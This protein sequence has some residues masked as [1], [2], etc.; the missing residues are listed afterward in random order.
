VNLAVVETRVKAKSAF[1]S[2]LLSKKIIFHGHLLPLSATLISHIRTTRQNR[3]SIPT[4]KSRWPISETPPILVYLSQFLNNLQHSEHVPANLGL[5]VEILQTVD[6]ANTLLGS[7]RSGQNVLAAKR[8]EFQK[9]PEMREGKEEKVIPEGPKT[10]NRELL[11]E[12]DGERKSEK[13][14]NR[15]ENGFGITGNRIE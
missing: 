2:V 10:P 13:K 7:Y 9:L 6:H 14:K 8:K 1:Q 15:K 12:I 4:R 3:V 11:L 5:T